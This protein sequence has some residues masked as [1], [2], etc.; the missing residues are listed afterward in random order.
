M[1]YMTEVVIDGAAMRSK[2]AIKHQG[3]YICIPC[4]T[5]DSDCCT[6]GVC[7]YT[8]SRLRG[9]LL[10]IGYCAKEIV[11]FTEAK[12]DGC[13]YGFAMSIVLKGQ[14]IMPGFP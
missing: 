5:H 7:Y 2:G 12:R 11:D 4:A 8:E 10:R 9:T 13:S 3:F 14:D 6:H 1:E